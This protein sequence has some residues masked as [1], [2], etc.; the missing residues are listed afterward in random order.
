MLQARC[1][2][3]GHR[4]SLAIVS[5]HRGHVLDETVNWTPLEVLLEQCLDPG[6][7]LKQT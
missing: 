4:H 1:S 6:N 5:V 3:I 2:L 7:V